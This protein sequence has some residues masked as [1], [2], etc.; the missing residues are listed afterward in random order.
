[1]RSLIGL[2][3]IAAAVLAACPAHAQQLPPVPG[4]TP[5]Y[6]A[7]DSMYAEATQA[8][9]NRLFLSACDKGDAAGCY[10][11]AELGDESFKAVS[12]LRPGATKAQFAEKMVILL[13]PRCSET[14]EKDSGCEIYRTFLSNFQFTR[15]HWELVLAGGRML[16]RRCL[17]GKSPPSSCDNVEGLIAGAPP[18]ERQA[19]ATWVD[20]QFEMACSTGDSATC[21]DGFFR[22]YG[23][24]TE[25]MGQRLFRLV[26]ASI[27]GCEGGA[28]Q[29]CG[30]AGSFLVR[31]GG[32]DNYDVTAEFFRL[33]CIMPPRAGEDDIREPACKNEKLVRAEI[34]KGAAKK[35]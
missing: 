11:L 14:D 24:L 21:H 33:A 23:D 15:N 29:V 35:P 28:P 22:Q 8:D 34:A 19:L 9:Q 32:P 20:A 17:A 31:F 4:A 7:A 5:E 26:E 16:A 25:E 13:R 12:A 30:E 2:A 18:A 3:T 10:R 1:M 6:Q 27:A